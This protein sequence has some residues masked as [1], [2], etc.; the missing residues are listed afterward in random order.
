[1]AAAL[2]RMRANL[3]IPEAFAQADVAFHLLTAAA[4]RSSV[5]L[6]LLGRVRYVLQV[7]VSRAVAVEASL[8]GTLHEHE[9]V[10]DAIASRDPKSAPTAMT[11]HMAAASGHLRRS[12]RTTA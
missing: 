11:E 8:Q 7:W 3:G 6:E 12:Q 2:D 5:I 9:L 1:V 10:Y 4:S